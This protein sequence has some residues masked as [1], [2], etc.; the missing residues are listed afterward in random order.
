MWTCRRHATLDLH[1]HVTEFQIQ[2]TNLQDVLL[3]SGVEDVW[4]LL[5]VGHIVHIIN[6][7]S[8]WDIALHRVYAWRGHTATPHGPRRH[9]T[10]ESAPAGLWRRSRPTIWRT[11]FSSAFSPWRPRWWRGCRPTCATG[12]RASGQRTPAQ[13][14]TSHTDTHRPTTH[15]PTHPQDQ[16]HHRRSYHKHGIDSMT[17]CCTRAAM[18]PYSTCTSKCNECTLPWVTDPTALIQ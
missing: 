15:T 11:W 6:S 13:D 7:L 14:A 10:A 1:V 12:S 4:W 9:I 8:E 17:Y 3:I 2:Y 18:A 16:G 5:Y